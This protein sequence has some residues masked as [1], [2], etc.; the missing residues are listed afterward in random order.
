MA[1]TTAALLDRYRTA[2]WTRALFLV[3]LIGGTG[4]ADWYDP[5]TALTGVH[6]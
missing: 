3:T 6:R 4:A 2:W 1:L 5:I